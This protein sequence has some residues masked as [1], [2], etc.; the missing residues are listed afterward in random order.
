VNDSVSTAQGRVAGEPEP[1]QAHGENPSNAAS[2]MPR[3]TAV[4]IVAMHRSGTSALSRALNLLGCDMPPRLIGADQWNAAG[5]WESKPIK[6]LNE[7]MLVSGGGEWSEWQEFNPNWFRSSAVQRFR[8]RALELVGSEF[9]DSPL[10]VFKD[11]RLSILMP[12]WRAIFDELGIEQVAIH[13]LR[14]PVE[15]AR[16]LERRNDFLMSKG[17]LLW[18]RYT[19]DGERGTR[20]M[21]RLFTTFDELMENPAG[22]I[23]RSQEIL[24]I[25]WPRNSDKARREISS[26][27]SADMRH[28]R[29]GPQVLQTLSYATDWVV[30]AYDTLSGFVTNGEDEAGRAALDAIRAEFSAAGNA[31]GALAKDNEERFTRIAR[32]QNERK[33]AQ[34]LRVELESAATAAKTEIEALRTSKAELERGLSNVQSRLTALEA[35]KSTLDQQ[36]SEIRQERDALLE[37]ARTM[38]QATAKAHQQRDEL[39][40][41]Q[42]EI[43]A[44]AVKAQE[45]AEAIQR[46]KEA[47]EGRHLA[48]QKERDT[49]RD[50]RTKLEADVANALAAAKAAKERADVAEQKDA[51]QRQA[52]AQ[53]REKL[54]AAVAERDQALHALRGELSSN[55]ETLEAQA[56]ELA[57][58]EGV[59]G[60]LRGELSS[61]NEALGAQVQE[62]AARDE[63][64]GSLR[65][66]LSAKE[67]A[68]ES[69]A[70]ELAERD[71]VVESLRGQL[72]AK[73]ETLE[74][75]VHELAERDHALG[76]LRG[77]VSA[78]NQALET[79]AKELA[80]R[81]DALGSLRGE[82]TARNEALETQAK[83]LAEREEALGSLRGDLSAKEEALDAQTRKLTE[84]LRTLAET[85]Q[86]SADY[87]LKATQTEA[88]AKQ[89]EDRSREL[90]EQ[91]AQERATHEA[92]IVRL[93]DSLAQTESALRQRQLETE[94]AAEALLNAKKV[95]HDERQADAEV[96]AALE[97]ALADSHD[98][99]KELERARAAAE[100][101]L[102]ARFQEI[103][104]LTEQFALREVELAQARQA[105]EESRQSLDQVARS[106]GERD[107]QL[108]ELRTSADQRAAELSQALEEAGR[109]RM[110]A[111]QSLHEREIE[112]QQ[113]RTAV[114]H[115]EAELASARQ[116]LEEFRQSQARTQH[117][118]AERAVEME[119]LRATVGRRDAELSRARHAAGAL[120]ESKQMAERSLQERD[121]QLEQLRATVNQREAD[122]AQAQA[123][124]DEN[125]RLLD[126]ARKSLQDSEAQIQQ[127]RTILT[128]REST[129]HEHHNKLAATREENARQ[130]EELARARAALQD[131]DAQFAKARQ[132]HEEAVRTAENMLQD[133]SRKKE[134]L[135]ATAIANQNNSVALYRRLLASLETM[136]AQAVLPLP[137]FTRRKTEQRQRR[138]LVEHAAFDADWY[139]TTYP[140]VAVS[141]LDPALHF[142]RHGMAEGRSPNA[143]MAALRALAEAG[144]NI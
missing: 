36:H 87:Q 121:D 141:T 85:E 92:D 139:V 71:G 103:A 117:M 88:L 67:E 142:I 109:S 119:E 138:L 100:A 10:F 73:D 97:R 122:L 86:S 108:H 42:A 5:Y 132:D 102:K 49:L 110:S 70:R 99:L 1:D 35:D 78:K 24:D 65:G 52:S 15:V 47:L 22:V 123:M 116:A 18:L 38:E 54:H 131:R 83:E 39:K 134:I 95:A 124:G 89:W 114:N 48:T 111:E 44:R 26:F 2:T 84:A 57:E 13:P 69:Q 20:G 72:S 58:R 7:E 130:A 93:Q 107:A 43:E 68:L 6:D 16:S 128:E 101:A 76:S 135:R 105:L 60:S 81:D 21:R 74:T 106:L 3:R 9:G 96:K 29:D 40:A 94:Q 56:G 125:G 51:A 136:L 143:E 4:M 129:L 45:K 75:Q 113:L 50:L 126:R 12:F 66:E 31:F 8:D 46:A 30:N 98:Q 63:A 41:A 25:Y 53:E 115:R 14:N 32:L 118:L 133:V 112:A 64:L 33:E 137:Q 19:L 61:K 79:Q 34:A 23:R 127:L 62:L 11:P 27:L 59:V 77:E 55:K 82:L 37:R 17:I 120:E 28:H 90:T 140:D 91:L 80:E 144:S 104:V